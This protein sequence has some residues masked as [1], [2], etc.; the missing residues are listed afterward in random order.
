MI[1]DLSYGDCSHAGMD[2]RCSTP[3]TLVMLSALHQPTSAVT[4]RIVLWEVPF[5]N[6]GMANALRLGLRI[7]P[8]FGFSQIRGCEKEV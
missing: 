5:V 7:Q 3:S 4:L 2:L 6:E 1:L 8:R